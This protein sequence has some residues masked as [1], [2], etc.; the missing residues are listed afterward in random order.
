MEHST[1]D[2]S[3]RIMNEFENADP[4]VVGQYIFQVPHMQQLAAHHHRFHKGAGMLHIGD[5][6]TRLV[7]VFFRNKKSAYALLK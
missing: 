6:L 7:N 2:K 3:A 4:Q 5:A 1:H